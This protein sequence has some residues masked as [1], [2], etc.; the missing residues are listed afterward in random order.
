LH[1]IGDSCEDWTNFFDVPATLD[2]LI[3]GGRISPLIA[4]TP[5]KSRLETRIFPVLAN[6][7]NQR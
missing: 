7:L 5:K 3:S 1:G 6:A 2:R 4:V